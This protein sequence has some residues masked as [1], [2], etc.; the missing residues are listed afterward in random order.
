MTPGALRATRRSLR[1]TQQQL[2]EALGVPQSTIWRWETGK[3]EI[4][5][6]QILR[7]AL[8]RLATR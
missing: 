6:P 1:L 4:Q 5:Q 3:H 2:A 7:L 8:E